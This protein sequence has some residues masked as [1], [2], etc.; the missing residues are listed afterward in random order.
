MFIVAPG[1]TAKDGLIDVPVVPARP[2]GARPSARPQGVKLLPWLKP[3]FGGGALLV[4]ASA[5]YLGLSHIHSPPP[6][7]TPDLRTGSIVI[8]APDMRQCRHLKFNNTTGAIKDEGTG[9]CNDSSDSAA[10]RLG[11]VSDSFQRR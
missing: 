11:Q 3:I 8:L 7:A 4:T 2:I 10:A 9:E 5:F 6:S 1:A